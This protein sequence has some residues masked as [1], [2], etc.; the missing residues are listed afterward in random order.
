MPNK[1]PAR[2]TIREILTEL[3]ERTNSNMRRLRILEQKA[4]IT[5][6][7]ITT[8]EE[9]LLEQ[10]RNVK[11]VVEA[12]EKTIIE[13]SE[14]IIK[15][16]GTIKDIIE[17]LKKSVSSTKIKELETLL[18][19]YSPLKSQFMTKEEVERLMDERLKDYWPK[20]RE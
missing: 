11:K 13:E 5:T 3:V 20:T 16:E 8:V 19:I 10:T 2:L 6:S 15:L 9:A 14:R 18:D 12:L 4:D 7:R 17:R 1:A